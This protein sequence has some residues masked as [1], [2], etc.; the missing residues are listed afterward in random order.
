MK[1]FK[2]LVLYDLKSK[3][4]EKEFIEKLKQFADSVSV[5]LADGEYKKQLKGS[6]LKGADALII[7]IFDYYDD[8]L[9]KDS[10]LKY[11]GTMHTDTSHF[12]KKILKEKRITLTN[13]DD[14]ATE[15]VAELTVSALL[16]ISRQTHKAMKFVED[17]NWGFEKFMGWE[18]KGKTLGIIGMGNIGNRVSEI[19]K[20]FGMNIV[21]FSR[22]KKDVPYEFVE[23]DKLLKESD[24]K[25]F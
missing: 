19:S 11:I 21:Y 23:L 8:S 25:K 16:N 4:L 14:Y 15:A 3:S 17:G 24:V 12:N 20:G 1:R 7:R 2:K 9:F 5:V 6:N 10:D 13:V 18:L 22:Q